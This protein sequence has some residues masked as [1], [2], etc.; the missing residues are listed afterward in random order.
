[1]STKTLMMN[2]L[3]L[4]LAGGLLTTAVAFADAPVSYDLGQ[5]KT[6]PL[7]TEDAT[8]KPVP[9]EVTKDFRERHRAMLDL[10]RKRDYAKATP[11]AEALLRDFA[12]YPAL[13]VETRETYA[14][15]LACKKEHFEDAIR[16]YDDLIAMAGRPSARVTSYLDSKRSILQ[17]LGKRDEVNKIILRTLEQPE[18]KAGQRDGLKLALA[19]N[20]LD[21]KE[22]DEGMKLAQALVDDPSVDPGTR[23]DAAFAAAYTADRMLKKPDLAYDLIMKTENLP[24]TKKRQW[25]MLER[26][27]RLSNEYIR[28]KTHGPQFDKALAALA[29]VY[30]N[31]E[32]DTEIRY[33]MAKAVIDTRIDAP[34]DPDRLATVAPVLAFVEK[35]KDK[36]DGRQR[37]TLLQ[38]VMDVYDKHA[39]E[40]PEAR[41]FAERIYNDEKAPYENRIKAIYV[42]AKGYRRA[43]DKAAEEAICRKG[44]VIAKES[45]KT[46]IDLLGRIAEM[47]FLGH[48]PEKMIAIY[49]E[50]GRFNDSDEM[51][52]LVVMRTA[53]VY[54]KHGQFEKAVEWYLAHG[55]K[56]AAA[57][58]C[59]SWDNKDKP[60][61]T[62]LYME[63]LTDEKAAPDDRYNAY[64]HLYDG[65]DLAKRYFKMFSDRK[66]S[67]HVNWFLTKMLTSGGYAYNAAYDQFITTY[68]LYADFVKDRKGNRSGT[69]YKYAVFAYLYKGDIAKAVAAA[70]E[71]ATNEWVQLKPAE[72]YALQMLADL[73]P[74]KGDQ[75]ALERACAEAD[76]RFAGE[77]SKKDRAAQL[78]VI[79]SAMNTG[80]LET[81]IRALSAY[82]D[83]L[84]VPTPR[85]SYTVEYSE[86]P[87]VSLANWDR[88]AKK[89]VEATMERHY[90]GGM[91]FL[92]TDVATGDRG[93]GIGSE[94]GKKTDRKHPTFSAVC[95]V[96]GIHFR[97]FLPTDKAREIQLGLVNG[98]LFEGYIA[99]GE[100]QPYICLL[101]DV[102]GNLDLYNTAY[103]TANHNRITEKD[104][105]FHRSQTVFTD[106]G[107]YNYIFFSWKAYATLIPEN[108]TVWDYE[109]ILWSSAGDE[110]WNGAESIHGRSTWGRLVFALPEK[111]RIA[112]LRNLLFSVKAEYQ[113]E[114]RASW[115]GRP[116]AFD[117]W[118]DRELGD[119][120]F[121]EA[122]L[123]PLVE[124][125]DGYVKELKA[126]M[127]DADVL[128]LAD[129]ALPAW[130]NIRYTVDRL[131]EQYLLRQLMS[132][133]TAE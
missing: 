27:Y 1:M 54:K 50:A 81:H 75:K 109:N 56:R 113:A 47:Y 30:E 119:P 127:P 62:K 23:V 105:K 122:S 95:D 118:Q 106:E 76:K 24:L 102:K 129:E 51:K 90:G 93:Q 35:N 18:L 80:R 73:L 31:E 7:V 68:E 9:P 5:I 98:G 121:Y 67:T 20:L 17:K 87:V 66:D 101:Q 36:L 115:G 107:V 78:D 33:R 125:L 88:L 42:I 10:L 60:L 128:R 29:K 94:K 59:D 72:R 45:P 43:Y 55:K 65:G 123:K 100:G 57:D 48:G 46:I 103:T 117:Q 52:D 69:I 104:K 132:E 4:V 79:G 74:R 40:K 19:R 16:V 41:A 85:L 130:K 126:D 77:V 92:E 21:M 11:L 110:C 86:T 108:G 32:L 25:T 38:R 91:E 39:P 97:Y 3:S 82:K 8:R 63:M 116:G 13:V 96:E 64:E 89:P 15:E 70:R 133:E 58:L 14:R 99:P 71:G 22:Y 49:N 112:I 53:D 61:A 124:K 34:E 84:Y 120:A 44:L 131:R 37:F 114:L 28:N 2:R 6:R 83:S 26:G 111:G 12:A